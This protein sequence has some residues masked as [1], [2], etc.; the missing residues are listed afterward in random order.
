MCLSHD[1]WG[2]QLPQSTS[3]QL[4]YRHVV[5]SSQLKSKIGHI[6][7]KGGT[8]RITLNID[9]TP[10]ESKSHTHSSHSQTSRL[11]TSSLFQC[12]GDV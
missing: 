4:H 8:L 12:I 10:I 3:V 1:R 9:D 7:T 6:L 11:L 5:F 2:V